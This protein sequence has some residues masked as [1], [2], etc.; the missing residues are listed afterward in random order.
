VRVGIRQLKDGEVIVTDGGVPIV[1]IVPA[2]GL[3][4]PQSVRDLAAKGL[5]EF[6]APLW[7]ELGEPVALRRGAKSAVAYA[8]EQRRCSFSAYECPGQ[9]R[10]SRARSSRSLPKTER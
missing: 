5:L 4:L 7:D 6:R 3:D 2:A 8:Q 10:Y 9:A 1:R